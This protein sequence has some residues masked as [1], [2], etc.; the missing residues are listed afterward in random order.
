MSFNLE[1]M[2]RLFILSSFTLGVL[3]SCSQKDIELNNDSGSMIIYAS[4]EPRPDVK[5]VIDNESL[6]ITWTAGDAI[7][8][9]FGASESSRFVT[10][11]SGSVAQFKGSIDVVTGGGEGLSDE[12]SLWGIYPYDA[13]N[14]CD[15]TNITLT[16]P[17]L[18]EAKENSFADG[19]F[20]QIARSQNFYMSFYNLCGSFRF[21]VAAS[22][23]KCVKLSGNNDELIAGKAVVSMEGEPAVE[24]IIYGEKELVMYAPDGG[25]FTPGV[26]YYFVLY[27]T[28]FKEGLSLT[29]YKE[30]T[31][32]SYK[33]LN[34]YTL[35][36]GR[37]SRFTDRDSGLTFENIPL[38]DWEE[39]ENIGGE[40]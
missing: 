9:F 15:G 8:V 6:E 34:P 38:Q 36:R 33:Y 2:K 27:P 35:E 26:N 3:V 37:F 31:Y 4:V 22:D 21:T 5:N 24:E 25:Y 20:P 28:E 16:L 30:D 18:Q 14:T 23:I 29:Y 19:L 1:D 12:T 10:S 13:N 17:S 39:G 7:N 11:Q 32:A 40:I